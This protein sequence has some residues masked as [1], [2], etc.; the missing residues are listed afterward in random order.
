PDVLN[1][2]P[3]EA[4]KTLVS[5]GLKPLFEGKGKV[6]LGQFPL[7][8]ATVP[9][10]TEIT[11]YLAKSRNG[12]DG[13]VVTVPDLKG[14]TMREAAAILGMMGLRLEP[15]GSGVAVNQT[16]ASGIQVKVDSLVKVKFEGVA[17]EPQPSDEPDSRRTTGI[18]EEPQEGP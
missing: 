18:P 10:G 17:K 5:Q 16:P 12:E 1:L 6:I 9:M 7:A 2:P 15:E 11:L 8:G 14:K 3:E 4:R 13:G